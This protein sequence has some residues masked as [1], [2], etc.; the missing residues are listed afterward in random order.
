LTKAQEAAESSNRTADRAGLSVAPRR[1]RPSPPFGGCR[2]CGV[3]AIIADCGALASRARPS[4]GQ[5]ASADQIQR[6]VTFDTWHGP[7]YTQSGPECGKTAGSPSTQRVSSV[8]QPMHAAQPVFR[9]RSSG[10]Q[11]I[12]PAPRDALRCTDVSEES[13]YPESPKTDNRIRG[14]V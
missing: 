1:G 4:T 7:G 8:Y 9:G 12:P 3:A 14:P 5:H 2:V 10:E 11:T 13:A 6:L